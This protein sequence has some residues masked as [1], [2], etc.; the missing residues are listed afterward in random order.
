MAMVKG[1]AKQLLARLPAPSGRN[2]S[3]ILCYHSIS[4][5]TAFADLTPD[6][7][8]AHL[9]WLA[10]NATVV[11]LADLS[12]P[13]DGLRVALTFDDGYRDNHHTV[14]P[15]LVD[16]GWPATFF[17][18]TGLLDGDPDVLAHFAAINRAPHDDIL[19]MSWRDAEDLVTAGME[20]GAH[21][22]THRNLAGLDPTTV[23][24]ELAG[25]RA[26]LEDRLQTDV[27]RA[28]YPFGR[29]AQHVTDTVTSAAR[30][31]G[32]VEAYAICFRPRRTDGWSVPRFTITGDDLSLLAAKV[33][34][35]LDVLGWWQ[36]TAPRWALDRVAFDP[37]DV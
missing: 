37:A 10:D 32:F 23:L 26:D 25:S 36:A 34:G 9:D 8:D 4:N 30:A 11:S 28:A 21:T 16:R 14:L 3:V 6:R 7:F 31:A 17:L 22:I 2:R 15:R 13:A 24:H 29:P 33:E 1:A 12:T 35:R 19:G 5:T 27:L 20:I 18:T